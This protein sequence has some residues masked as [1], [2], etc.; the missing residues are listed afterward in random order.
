MD[1][2]QI[3][4]RARKLL[5]KAEK[6]KEFTE[7]LQKLLK[8]IV[9]QGA[10]RDHRRVIPNIG[11]HY[12]VPKP[13]LWTIASEFRKF[14]TKN[15]TK[16]LTL[17]KTIWNEGSYEAKQ[18]VGKSLE[19]FGPKNP[20]DTLHFISSLLP[21]IDNWSVCD[22]LAMYAVEPIVCS[23]PE[24]VLPFSEKWIKDKN[25]WIK[26]FGVVTLRGYKKIP[27][28]DKVFRILDLVMKENEPDVKKAVSWILREIAKKNP[29]EVAKFLT[30]WAKTN[31]SNNTKWIIKDGMK[32]LS[33]DEQK[34]ILGLLIE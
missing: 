1:K 2:I 18:I 8:F 3:Q 25:K 21:D 5:E 29:N 15:E 31:P 11:K 12:G 33:N 23:N 4:K 13:L 28:A 6:S 32:K 20:K 16:A 30:K 17:L 9:D 27:V 7:G 24:L 19:K 10:I 14:A 22:C 34:K 26:R